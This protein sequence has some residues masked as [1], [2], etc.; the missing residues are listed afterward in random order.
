[1]AQNIVLELLVHRSNKS[2]KV[3]AEKWDNEEL[4]LDSENFDG[5]FFLTEKRY[6]E[7]L[8]FLDKYGSRVWWKIKN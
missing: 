6:N 7:L 1:M 3:L 8:D 5:E 4:V 2:K